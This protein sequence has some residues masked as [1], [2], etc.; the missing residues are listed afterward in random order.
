[1]SR[2][3][4]QRLRCNL[5]H[6]LLPTSPVLFLTSQSMKVHPSWRWTAD[7]WGQ[8]LMTPILKLPQVTYWSLWFLFYIDIIPGL[9]RSKPQLLTTSQ[10]TVT[11]ELPT[12]TSELSEVT[13]KT[14]GPGSPMMSTSVMH[15]RTLRDTPEMP[16]LTTD[17]RKYALGLDSSVLKTKSRPT[18]EFP[19]LQSF[20]WNVIN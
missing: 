19:E 9:A 1:M 12:L 13:K 20:K 10:K 6:H 4:Q 18:P 5:N 17:I 11:P 7:P 15:S 3:Q 2:S 14:L 8:S 16:E